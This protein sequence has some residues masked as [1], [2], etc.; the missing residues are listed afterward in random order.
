[1]P[2]LRPTKD[3]IR[4]MKV[5]LRIHGTI[6]SI[7]KFKFLFLENIQSHMHRN[8]TLSKSENKSYF[9]H[10][11]MI[12][13]HL[14]VHGLPAWGM[15]YTFPDFGEEGQTKISGG[16]CPTKGGDTGIY[17]WGSTGAAWPIGVN[18]EETTTLCDGFLIDLKLWYNLDG[19]NSWTDPS[20]YLGNAGLP[21]TGKVELEYRAQGNLYGKFRDPYNDG[22]TNPHELDFTEDHKVRYKNES[23]DYTIAKFTLDF[24]KTGVVTQFNET[25]PDMTPRGCLA[26]EARASD[27]CGPSR[28]TLLP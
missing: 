13:F 7:F 21:Y 22:K 10:C 9:Q 26:D 24:G 4:C 1:M 11:S 17:P 25:T 18:Y 23:D 3:P 27:Y 2:K 5:I 19:E 12:T 15:A 20:M 14:Q 28:G 16:G 6:K 8:S